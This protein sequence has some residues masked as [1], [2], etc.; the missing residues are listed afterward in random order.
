[1][2][3]ATKTLPSYRGV[4]CACCRQ[5]IPL[6][7]IVEAMQAAREN[8]LGLPEEPNG[9]MFILRC[10]ACEK[11]M[12]YQIGDIAEFEGTP[13]SRAS[14]T[15]GASKLMQPANPLSRAANAWR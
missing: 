8:Q 7:K 13:R 11:E 3:P 1:M 9:R 6:P 5:P 12:P 14:R 2:D 4:S 15:R 10:R